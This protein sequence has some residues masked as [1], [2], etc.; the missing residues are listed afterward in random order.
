MEKLTRE[1]EFLEKKKIEKKKKI[2]PKSKKVTLIDKKPL[3]KLKMIKLFFEE[4]K[5][6]KKPDLLME[7]IERPIMKPIEK[8][9][10][11]ILPK[12]KPMKEF[13]II[14]KVK[15]P[16]EQIFREVK[17]EQKPGKEKEKILDKKVIGTDM[18]GKKPKDIIES[19]V[20]KEKKKRK[21]I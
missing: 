15:K 14:T 17:E 21:K 3:E 7:K 16:T 11:E 9:Q 20:E 8:S 5:K 13:K 18:Y 4:K 6:V 12:E 10:V 19:I 2:Y 1:K